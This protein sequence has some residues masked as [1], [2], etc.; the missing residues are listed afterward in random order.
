MEQI[1]G[2]SVFWLLTLGALV[3]WLAQQFVG[4]GQG[5]G[6]VPN[7]VLGAVGSIISGLLAIS[8]N[9]P[10]SLLFGFLGCLTI[11]FLANVFSMGDH[12]H[13]KIEINKKKS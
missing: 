2:E 3:G 13:N 12:Q 5:F 9:M 4:Q 11:L 8:I 6:M 7:L 10:G 1:T